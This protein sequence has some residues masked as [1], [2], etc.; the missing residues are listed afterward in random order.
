MIFHAH[1]IVSTPPAD[2]LCCRPAH[3]AGGS[4]FKSRCLTGSRSK[5]S[6]LNL[7][8]SSF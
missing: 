3:F 2:K 8:Q 5:V 4:E 6:L 1:L 7:A